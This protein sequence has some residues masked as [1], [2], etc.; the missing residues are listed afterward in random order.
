MGGLYSDVRLTFQEYFE[1]LGTKAQTWG[2]PFAALLGGLH[3]QLKIGIPAIGG[4][5]SMSGTFEDIHVP[6][7]LCSFAVSACDVRNVIS[8]EFKNVGSNVIL[9]TMP[10]S[11]DGMPDMDNLM[12][13]YSNI[14]ALMEQGKIVSAKVVERGGIAHSICMMAFGN[15]N[16]FMF[17]KNTWDKVENSIFDAQYG[18]IVLELASGLSLEDLNLGQQYILLGNVT[19]SG[20]I[21]A[22]DSK[23]C[24]NALMDS[25]RGKLDKVFP[26]LGK[27]LDVAD[28]EA[29]IELFTVKE[30]NFSSVSICKTGALS[31]LKW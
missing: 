16:G 1:K 12:A 26:E 13:E 24:V 7:T 6:P 22:G 30:K 31:F 27:K 15:K 10:V 29:N 11:E 5:D 23:L 4:K 3:A 18:D 9:Y 25:W 2:K 8:T 14:H 17:D 21:E 28:S 19:D 20:I